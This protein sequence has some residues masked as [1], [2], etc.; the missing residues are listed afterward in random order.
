MLTSALVVG[1]GSIGKRHYRL[2]QEICADVW[3]VSKHASTAPK[4]FSDLTQALRTI[5]PDLIILAS[6]TWQHSEQVSL[7]ESYCQGKKVLVEKPYT[8]LEAQ[9]P[10]SGLKNHYFIGYN[11]RFHPL[12]RS[13]KAELSQQPVLSGTLTCSS[14]L[15]DWRPGQ[16][17]RT[18]YSAQ[19]ERGGGVLLDISHE[20]DYLTYCLG[21]I[22]AVCAFNAKISPLE[23]QS[24]DVLFALLRFKSGALI[25]LY[26]DYFGRWPVRSGLLHTPTK[27]LAFDLRAGSLLTSQ[28]AGIHS[29]TFPC[30]RDTSYRLQLQAVLT[31]DRNLCNLTMAQHLQQTFL[32]LRASH[33]QRAWVNVP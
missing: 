27:T 26:L 20:L 6:E 17:Y 3:L 32:A 2:L 30:E 23:I 9:A 4:A 5:N 11:L 1:Y 13:L 21:E 33:Q 16:D 22:Q 15:P 25:H 18:S 12:I 8:N 7:I 28:A 14:Y 24:D 10:F 19:G 29:V 31:D